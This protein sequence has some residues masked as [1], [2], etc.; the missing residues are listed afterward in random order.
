ME[1]KAKRFNNPDKWSLDFFDGRLS[2]ELQQY[3]NRNKTVKKNSY[4]KFE[5]EKQYEVEHM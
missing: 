1:V 3:I 2:R 5:I 4:L